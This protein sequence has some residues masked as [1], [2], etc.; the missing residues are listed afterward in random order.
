MKGTEQVVETWRND[1][2]LPPLTIVSKDPVHAPDHVTVVQSP[3]DAEL[4]KLM[5]QAQIHVCPSTA[6]GWGHYITE[7]MSVGAVVVT[8]DA[9][10]MNEHIRPEWGYLLGVAKTRMHH[11]AIQTYTTADMIS[12]AVRRAAALTPERRRNVGQLARNHFL[13]RNAEFREMALRLVEA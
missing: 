3:S 10:P 12:K 2:T 5:N 1:P 7:A 9:S 6:E 4:D 11:Q 8:T 13:R